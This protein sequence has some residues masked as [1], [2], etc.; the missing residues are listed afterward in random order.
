MRNIAGRPMCVPR[1]GTRRRLALILALVS[2][3]LQAGVRAQQPPKP[4]AATTV[5]ERYVNAI[6]GKKAVEQ[7][8]STDVSG[9]VATADGRSGAFTQRS[10]RPQQFSVSLSW[11][12]A[13]WRT[14]FNGISAWQDDSAGGVRTLFGPVASRVR[15]EA[16]YANTRFVVSEKLNQ[17][18][19]ARQ[20]RVRDRPVVV[21]TAVTSDGTQRTLFFDANNYL[22]VKDEQETDAGVDERF[23]DD[24]R[25]VGM[26]MEPHR[27]E[28]HRNGE[29]L[30]IAVERVT[31]N[32]AIDE[33]AFDVPLSPPDPRVES[34][35]VLAAAVRGEERA[36]PLRTAYAYT[37]STSSARMDDQGRVTR[38]EGATYEVLYFG[39]GGI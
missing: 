13:R 2:C 24:Y 29:V 9:R 5:I 21:L 23:F 25:R 39:D 38:R 15:A 12:D 31:H 27:I 26:V 28:W 33:Q 10:K 1:F 22:L 20:G 35:A 7:I 3:G 17:V 32:A 8:L 34:D 4:P 18:F 11:D 16:G 36:N 30:Q 37:R 6:G 14:G 19:L